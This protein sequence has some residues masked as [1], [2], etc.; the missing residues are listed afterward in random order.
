MTTI[1][2]KQIN[3]LFIPE[4]YEIIRIFDPKT[5]DIYTPNKLKSIGNNIY[6]WAKSIKPAL[7]QFGD[8]SA[9]LMAIKRCSP[10]GNTY[11]FSNNGSFLSEYLLGSQYTVNKISK[12][13]E[14]S[15]NTTGIYHSIHIFYTYRIDLCNIDNTNTN[16]RIHNQLNNK[17]NNDSR[18]NELITT[19]LQLRHELINPLNV[20]KLSGDQ[21]RNH[22]RQNNNC[23]NSSM[24]NIDKFNNIILNEVDNSLY[25]IDTLI[26]EKLQS[27]QVISLEK[28][29][30]TLFKSYV[31]TQLDVINKT[32]FMFAPVHVDWPVEIINTN[33]ILTHYVCVNTNYMKIILDNVFKNIYGHIDSESYYLYNSNIN[34]YTQPFNKFNILIFGNEIQLLISNKINNNNTKTNDNI[35]D[36]YW[37]NTKTAKNII[38][39]YNLDV[40]M[41]CKYTNYLDNS[42]TTN[43]ILLTEDQQLLSQSDVVTK[44][45]PNMGIGLTLINNLCKKMNFKWNMIDNKN[46]ICFII[47]IPLQCDTLHLGQFYNPVI[48]QHQSIAQCVL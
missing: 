10:D 17:L 24:E 16:N 36:K 11:K 1:E 3:I 33:Y 31:Q 48:P 40:N 35:D 27:N 34:S 19:T 8:F 32:Y 22:I 12:M 44:K 42:T 30:L 45:K 43:N 7:D 37:Q 46:H 6:S 14:I 4:T 26:N 9:F 41:N 39:K 5:G 38:D 29:P 18:N 47:T 25:I 15:Y 23:I 13:F 2:K 28:L 20:I 21:I